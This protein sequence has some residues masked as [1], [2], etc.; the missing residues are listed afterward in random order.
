MFTKLIV[1]IISLKRKCIFYFIF[2]AAPRGLAGEDPSSRTR[3]QFGV[4]TTRP[5]G[6]SP[7]IP[8]CM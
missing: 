2:L 3:D 8:R 4:L 5:P 7:I 1:I 6:N